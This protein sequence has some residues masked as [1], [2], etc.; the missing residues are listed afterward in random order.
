MAITK[1]EGKVADQICT[2]N[3][4][5]SSYASR[6]DVLFISQP[7]NDPRFQRPFYPEGVRA[8]YPGEPQPYEYAYQNQ[9]PP[10]A[11]EGY[12]QGR[13]EGGESDL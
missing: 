11:T 7:G 5:L 10:Y 12:Y 2:G 6:A 3:S 13:R 9:R 4:H 1:D 8:N